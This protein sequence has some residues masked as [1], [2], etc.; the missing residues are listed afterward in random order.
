MGTGDDSSDLQH[1]SRG[2]IEGAKAARGRSGQ[3]SGHE[4]VTEVTRAHGLVKAAREA[5]SGAEAGRAEQVLA[6][7][8]RVLARVRVRSLPDDES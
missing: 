4:F 5:L 2:E 7:V 8:Q 6:E 3:V 1:E